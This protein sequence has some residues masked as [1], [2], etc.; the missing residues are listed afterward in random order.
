MSVTQMT[1]PAAIVEFVLGGNA[2]FTLVSKATGV[3]F[4]FRANKA[5]NADS[6]LWFV[7]TLTGADNEN[8]Y[9]YT[10]II[11]R[12]F[13]TGALYFKRTDKSV[14]GEDAAS[15]KALAWFMRQ[16]FENGALAAALDKMEFWH[17]G[18]CGCC[19]RK[20]TVPESIANGI[21]PECSKKA[22]AAA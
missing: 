12:A 6:D 3:R 2:T 18:R 10:G 19:G 5:K 4:T 15:F 20:L 11:R 16:T 22:F 14:I 13:K 8:S 17:E 21:G 7:S 9:A 1:A